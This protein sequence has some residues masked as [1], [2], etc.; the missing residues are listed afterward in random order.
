MKSMT[1]AR[2]PIDAMTPARMESCAERRPDRALFQIGQR[3]G[4]RA[5][6]ERDDQV[7]PSR[8]CVMPVICPLS[9]IRPS[10]VGADITRLSSTIAE[11]ASDVRLG[12]PAEPRR[13]ILLER[14]V[15]GR[16]VVFV[17]R[18]RGA[19]QIVPATTAAFCARSRDRPTPAAA[20]PRPRPGSISAVAAADC[21]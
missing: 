7:A 18:L 10:I 14:E 15:H 2:P 19:A 13:S 12:E 21:C 16:P 17:E 8:R 1:S 11:Q 6:L 20:R 3:S 5:G 4:Q 9:V